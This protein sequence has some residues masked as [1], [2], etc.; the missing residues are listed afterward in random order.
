[1]ATKLA[2]VDKGCCNLPVVL[3]VPLC[4]RAGNSRLR[5]RLHRYVEPFVERGHQDP[6]AT[7]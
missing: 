2:F 1:M 6:V 7:L 3:L 4:G 5:F